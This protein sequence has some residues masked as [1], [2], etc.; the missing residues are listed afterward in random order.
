MSGSTSDFFIAFRSIIH[1]YMYHV[2]CVYTYSYHLFIKYIYQ[3]KITQVTV[4][5]Y[6]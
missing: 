1:G 4:W 3:L 2:H 6:I 5:R